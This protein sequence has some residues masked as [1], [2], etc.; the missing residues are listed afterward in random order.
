MGAKANRLEV[1]VAALEEVYPGIVVWA[2][3]HTPN[4][5]DSQH[6]YGALLGWSFTDSAHSNRMAV[7]RGH[8]IA[9]LVERK[10]NPSAWMVYLATDDVDETA[11]IVRE[12]GGTIVLPPTDIM[13]AGRMAHCTDPTGAFFGLWQGRTH[14]GADIVEEAGAMIWGEAYSRNLAL[15][16]PFY[17]RVFG[18][19]GTRVDSPGNEYWM[20]RRQGRA[21]F[22][23]MQMT[24]QF[25]PHVPSHWNIYFVARDVDTA[26]RH[27]ESLGG[28]VL[29]EPFD[30]VYGRIAFVADSNG[31]PFWLIDPATPSSSW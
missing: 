8:K 13:D 17:E 14:R 10:S 20:L 3:L 27:V 29:D 23:V 4:L 6:F 15:A 9:G 2:E 31:A 11:R 26:A 12:A 5:V 30:T 28:K 1:I 16:R 18:L 7:L 24:D 19:S 22:E 21:F 25:P